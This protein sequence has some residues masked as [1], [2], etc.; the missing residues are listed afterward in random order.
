MI[1]KLHLAVH[2]SHMLNCWWWLSLQHG[3]LMLCLGFSF[4]IMPVLLQHSHSL[5][6]VF[7]ITH[8]TSQSKNSTVDDYCTI[9][10]YTWIIID[11]SCFKVYCYVSC[12]NT[13]T[14]VI[15]FLHCGHL[16]IEH[17]VS[18]HYCLLPDQVM[19]L[20]LWLLI[21]HC[22]YQ[23]NFHHVIVFFFLTFCLLLPIGVDSFLC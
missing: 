22:Y 21:I 20:V 15:I 9:F 3:H 5:C 2:L 4:S 23:C 19:L 11:S 16:S 8:H 12:S 18:H 13:Q 10:T 17:S 7:F 14:L 6:V 1:F